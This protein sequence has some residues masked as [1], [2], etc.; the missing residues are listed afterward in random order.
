MNNHNSES[1]NLDF[2][3]SVAQNMEWIK[4]MAVEHDCSSGLAAN[5]ALMTMTMMDHHKMWVAVAEIQKQ[6]AEI[7]EALCQSK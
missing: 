7:R 2:P 5:A 4:K 3:G 1:V 6:L